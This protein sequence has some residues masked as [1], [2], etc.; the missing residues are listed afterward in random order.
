MGTLDNAWLLPFN[1]AG[2]PFPAGET[3]GVAT[4]RAW[5]K[6]YGAARYAMQWRLGSAAGVASA[7][8]IYR[9]AAGRG[10]MQ[11]NDT[12]PD[13]DPST[14]TWWK[15]EPASGLAFTDLPNGAAE[16]SHPIQFSGTAWTYMMI[17]I[18]VTTQIDQFFFAVSQK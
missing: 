9:T 1:T 14:N 8:N 16:S 4:H 17:E 5:F 10:Q 18:V 6:L 3:L 15:Q 11:P 2:T 13:L 7:I 12:R